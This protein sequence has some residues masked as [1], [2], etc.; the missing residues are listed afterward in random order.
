MSRQNT[1][2]LAALSFQLPP[3]SSEI[4]LTPEGPTF[5]AADGSGRPLDVSAWKIDERIAAKVIA[6]MKARTNACPVDYEHQTL[7]ADR[8]GQPAPAAGWFRELEWRPGQGLFAVG[9]EWTPRAAEMLKA[10][11]YRYASPVFA[12]D[13]VTGE[14]E[15]VRMAALTNT[16]GLDGMAS[17]ALSAALST[18][19]ADFL[20]E[21]DPQMNETLK[22]LLAAL[23][24]PEATDETAALS[25][26]AALKAK[27]D[28][29]SA[30]LAALKA[31][32]PDAAS[33]PLE[34][35]QKIVQEQQ[36]AIAALSA[37]FAEGEI[38][39][40]F[41]AAEKAGKLIT[42]EYRAVLE[43]QYKSNLVGLKAVLDASPVVAAL[44]GM[45]SAAAKGGG[46]PPLAGVSDEEQ[47]VMKAMGLSADE[48]LKGKE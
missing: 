46:K 16:P 30:E 21:G 32:A 13:R 5:R 48:F 31:R 41:E 34:T 43:A 17:V 28:S 27:A 19:N 12:Y 1:T 39:R 35:V 23:G 8:N 14:V 42:P 37:Q 6:R 26:A 44:K 9:V 47:A 4:Q 36:G 11:E 18:F 2:A 45:Q 40:L 3:A 15:D 10:G 20:T 24:L 38:T 25:A 7:L 22:K 29:V 33:V